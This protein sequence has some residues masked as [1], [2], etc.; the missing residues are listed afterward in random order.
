MTDVSEMRTALII[1]VIDFIVL[2][3]E[4]E[5]T[6]EMSVNFNVT[7]VCYIPEDSK[8]HTCFLF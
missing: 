7:T 8:L 4:A 3:I 6:F 1:R 2:M 5:R